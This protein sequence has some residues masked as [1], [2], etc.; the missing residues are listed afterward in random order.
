MALP[1]NS[2]NGVQGADCKVKKVKN[3]LKDRAN[4]PVA[5][6]LYFFICLGLGLL[7]EY[8]L[9]LRL[10]CLPWAA[11]IT[12]SGLLL[13]I[14][15]YFAASAFTVLIKN[16]TPFDHARPTAVIVRE[17]SFKFSRNPMY[18][19]LLILIAGIAVLTCS[20]WLYIA[21]PILFILLDVLAVR[22]EEKYLSQKFEK[23]YSDYKAEVRRWI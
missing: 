20:L 12:L 4:V 23:Y 10:V 22:P 5:P 7:L 16:N 9:P 6:P 17:G 13:L 18:L 15:G 11:R 8:V 1:S 3:N 21:I 14:S 19:S 2:T